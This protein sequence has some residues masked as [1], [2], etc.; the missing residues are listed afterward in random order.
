V[1]ADL[2]ER[3]GTSVEGMAAPRPFAVTHRSVL[4]IALP[5]MLTHL[6][7][8]LV[9]LVS[10]GVIG[11]LG[12]AALVGG[13][14][15]AAVVFDVVFVS[16]NFLR[17]AT[18]GFTAQAVGA[19]DKTEEQT[20]LAGGILMALAIGLCLLALQAPI[21]QFG[22]SLLG[23]D[24]AVADAAQ[25]YFAIRIWSAPCVLFNYVVFG[26]ILGR[27]EAFLALAL[28][29]L[30]N[31]LGIGL[32]LW[33]VLG[34]GHGVAG[35]AWAT[36][37]AEAVTALAG[38]AIVLIRTDRRHW[39]LG[40]LRDGSRVRR[41][42]G[43]NADMMVRSIALLLGISFFT[44]ESGQFG[45]DILAANTILLRY[46]FLAVSFLDGVAAA[47]EQLAGRS[48]GARYR[49]AFER[50]VRLTTL[51]GV[52]FAV[53][54]AAAIL[55]TGPSVIALM[56]PT[57]AVEAAA[58][59]FLPWA[60]ALPL[61]GVIAFQMDG[62]FIGATWSREMRNMMLA[63]LAI[64]MAAEAVLTPHWGNHG[65]W[66]SLLIFQGARSIFFRLWMIRLVPRT[67]A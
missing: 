59:T 49:P 19:G 1:T 38:A 31:G 4:A 67:F 28:Q 61:S 5:M 47:A 66:L 60:V 41:L 29:T 23:A 6:S 52:G 7:T 56:A 35:A 50:T 64:Y 44:R 25:T 37:V 14:A 45:T 11:Q 42:F 15:L 3:G 48:V 34:E 58:L 43:V 10:T 33:L 21:G 53:A 12:N 22:L 65:L 9:G 26:W 57:P 46:Y 2:P 54:M 20:M 30:L 16:C 8:P 55:F 13:V 27:G 17:G 63:S 32:A 62:I 39:H 40:L 18:T 51:W 24:G 36:L